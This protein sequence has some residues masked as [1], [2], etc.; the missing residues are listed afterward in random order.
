MMGSENPETLLSQAA[1]KSAEIAPQRV[2]RGYRYRLAPTPEQEA[3]FL[4]ISGVCRLVW[5]LALEQ[6]ETFLSRQER[7]MKECRNGE[8]RKLNPERHRP[9]YRTAPGAEPIAFLNAAEQSRQLTELGEEFDFI[10]ECPRAPKART[11]QSLE[12]AYKRMFARTGGTPRYKR[13]GEH[14]AF[15]Y[16][17]KHGVKV[18]RLNAKRA[19]V[20]LPGITNARRRDTWI[21]MR[22]H[23]DLPDRLLEAT[24]TR[25]ACGWDIS[26]TCS[27]EDMRRDNGASVGIDRG[28]AIPAMLSTGEPLGQDM[29]AHLAKLEADRRRAQ[30]KASRG[31]YGSNRNRRAMRRVEKVAEKQARVR[32][33]FWH[34]ASRDIANRFGTVVI[35]DSISL[36][37]SKF[38]KGLKRTR[39]KNDRQTR[40]RR[41]QILDM[42][43][44]DFAFMLDYKCVKAIRVEPRD[45][46]RMCGACGHM[47][48]K[49][50][51]NQADFFCRNCGHG[52]GADLDAALNIL[53]RGSGRPWL[54]VEGGT[55]HPEKRQSE[56]GR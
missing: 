45:V 38:E 20:H 31:V 36:D 34:K 12:E 33:D 32:N 21:K 56:A 1:P 44:H 49:I 14:D 13:K 47:E 53:T 10:R 40:D 4:K 43:W 18:E 37:A 41:R 22:I 29:K 16:H 19:R 48:K 5:N 54:D 24:I 39:G 28:V 52:D 7:E 11:L 50:R 6:R 25:K 26:F 17:M 55:G 27:I 46:M 3:V 35:E 30:K 15:S 51:E 2:M 23:R 42:G 9:A 8:F